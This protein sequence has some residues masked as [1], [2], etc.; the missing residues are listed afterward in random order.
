LGSLEQGIAFIVKSVEQTLKP[1]GIACH[2]TEYN[3]SSNDQT[4]TT[5]ATVIYR[6]RDIDDLI[7]ELRRRGHQVDVFS[8]APDAHE[9]DRY[10][11]IAPFSPHGHLKLLLEGYAATSMALT[12]RRG[13]L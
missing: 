7:A 4:V 8:V 2:T 13:P 10:V 6:R 3:L 1:G 9:I 5:G 12:I 11:D